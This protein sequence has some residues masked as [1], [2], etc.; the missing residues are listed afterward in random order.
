MT[1]L[2]MTWAQF[3]IYFN[4]KLSKIWFNYAGSLQLVKN[5]IEHG[6]KIDA[7]DFQGKTPL[8]CAVMKGKY[9]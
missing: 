4:Q 8:L 3:K 1:W 7:L 2:T 6:A 9:Y 5:L